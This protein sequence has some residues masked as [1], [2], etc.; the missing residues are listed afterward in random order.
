MRSHYRKKLNKLLGAAGDE[1]FIQLLWATNVLQSEYSDA[2]RDYIHPD[3]IPDGAITSDMKS[4]FAV[5]KWEIE[6]LA[7][8]IMTVPKVRRPKNGKT[9]T[10]RWDHFQASLNC[11]IWLRKLENAEYRI[12]KKREEVFIEMGRIAARQFEWQRGFDNVP[13]F[14]RNAFVYGQGECASYFE[15]KHGISLNRFSQIGFMLYVLFVSTPV[16]HNDS[17]WAELGVSHEEMERVLNLISMP[18]PEAAN[19]ARRRR[20]RITHTADKPSILRQSP[21]LR[22][23]SKGERIRAPLPELIIERVTSGVFYDVVSGGGTIRDNYGKRFE[24]YC[25]KYLADVL[26]KFGWEGEF[27]YRKKPN[28]FDTPDI[29]CSEGPL[30]TIAFECKATRMSQEAMFGKDPFSARGYEDLTKAVF[31]LWR[32]FSHCRRGYADR[33]IAEDAVGVILTLDNWLMHSLTLQRQ[34]LEKAKRMAETKDPEIL[35]EDRRPVVF[36]AAPELERILTVA[37]EESFKKALLTSVSD[38]F[39]GWRL[40]G[41]FRELLAGA[42]REKRSFP[43]V[44]ELGSLLP[45]WDEMHHAGLSD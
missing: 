42:E 3:T 23:G 22:F 32:F 11:A 34:V 15:Q 44:D 36:V 31:Q 27:S 19:L 45:W 6:T 24:E 18:F 43:Y 39:A 9:R 35:E 12:R 2:A 40:D 33:T 26:P 1:E 28:L 25:A 5:Q 30:L 4:R 29:L 38:E 8:E 37:T 13:Q 41:V 21:C 14:Y 17:S 16:M 7:N 10:L 20:K